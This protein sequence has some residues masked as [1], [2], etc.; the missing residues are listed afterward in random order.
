MEW[1]FQSSNLSNPLLLSQRNLSYLT[2]KVDWSFYQKQLKTNP[3][4]QRP[5]D[6]RIVPTSVGIQ[7]N[8]KPFWK[9]EHYQNGIDEYN[10]NVAKHILGIHENRKGFPGGSMV[11]NPPANSG[12]TDVSLNP[13]LGRSLE[14]DMTIHSSIL[15]WE[16]PWTEEPG[17]L[18]S[19]G[20]Q[21][22]W[23]RL[24]SHMHENWK[25]IRWWYSGVIFTFIKH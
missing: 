5:K 24:S 15:A 18:Q 10:V 11:K 19:M 13:A 8:T 22:S 2:H 16:I 17:E 6:K 20:S 23:T 7:A 14:E 9:S 3:F 21:K 25:W 1:W 12:D 4:T